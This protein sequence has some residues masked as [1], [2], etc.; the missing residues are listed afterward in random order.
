[1]MYD[2]INYHYSNNEIKVI[3]KGFSYAEGLIV[4]VDAHDT[5]LYGVMGFHIT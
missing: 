1:M 2:Q 5:K 4:K 3:I